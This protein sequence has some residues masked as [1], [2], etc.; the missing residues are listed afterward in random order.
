MR[1]ERW[2]RRISLIFGFILLSLQVSAGQALALDSA[3]VL[4]KGMSA[5]FGENRIF[6]PVTDQFNQDGN[7]QP[8]GTPFNNVPLA[9]LF[10]APPGINFGTTVVSLQQTR[11]ELEYT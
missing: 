2:V 10:G 9:S 1:L 8:L 7:Q 11:V 6:F 3:A 5:L 4:P